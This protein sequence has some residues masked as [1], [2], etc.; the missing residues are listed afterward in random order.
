MH[1]IFY[2]LEEEKSI[3]QK[4]V[5][6]FLDLPNASVSGVTVLC[7]VCRLSLARSLITLMPY[8]NVQGQSQ[9]SCQLATQCLVETSTHMLT[10]MTTTGVATSRPDPS[11]NDSTG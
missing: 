2:S 1:I 8:E 10:G 3:E 7:R 4:L 9:I 11:T 6:M 5:V